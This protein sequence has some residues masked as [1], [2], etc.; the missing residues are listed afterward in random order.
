MVGV[1]KCAQFTPMLPLSLFYFRFP[2]FV[3]YIA[4]HRD[5]AVSHVLRALQYTYTRRCAPY[6]THTSS[7]RKG[8]A[9]CT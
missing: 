8:V 1:M 6:S 7:S 4:S 3:T 9:P 2:L 5:Q